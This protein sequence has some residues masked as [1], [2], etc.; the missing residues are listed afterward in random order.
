MA[1]KFSSGLRSAI[2]ATAPLRTALASGEIR[3]YGGAIPG[4]ADYGLDVSNVLLCTIKTDVGAGLTFEA[5]APGGVITKTLAEIWRGDVVLSG[6]ATFYRHVL[7]G[8]IGN[9]SSSAPRIQ[10]AIGQVGADL[11]LTYTYLTLGAVQSIEAYSL[12]MPEA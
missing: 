5:T 10:G 3:I 7:A 6:Q 11:N 9:A 2:L 1:L 12:T 8:D 4:S